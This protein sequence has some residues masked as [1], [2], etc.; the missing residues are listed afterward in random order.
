[1]NDCYNTVA[2]ERQIEIDTTCFDRDV[3]YRAC[4]LLTEKA[5][6]W[7]KQTSHGIVVELIAKPDE[8]VEVLALE[9]GNLLL[10]QAVRKEIARET[11]DIRRLIL[12]RALTVA[13]R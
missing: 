4:Y 7:L 5:W 9:L 10:D 1:M 6:L 8:Q 2:A 3:V 12:Q 13:G 11:E